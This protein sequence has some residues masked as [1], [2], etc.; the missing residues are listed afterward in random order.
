ME[1]FNFS[2]REKVLIAVFLGVLGLY[3]IVNFYAV[4]TFSTWNTINDEIRTTE[5]RLKR[6]KAIIDRK[7]IIQNDYDKL[8]SDRFGKLLQ[9]KSGEWLNSIE[10]AAGKNV[11]IENISPGPVKDMKTF[12]IQTVDIECNG[13]LIDL[14]N[15]IYKIIHSP[16]LLKVDVLRFKVLSPTKNTIQC[17]LVISKLSLPN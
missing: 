15:F 2:K 9:S 16:Y 8:T 7:D 5:I 6:N 11:W 1:I 14:T 3:L 10:K 13:E 4:P 12:Q 17:S